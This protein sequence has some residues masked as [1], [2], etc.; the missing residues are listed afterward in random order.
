M[1]HDESINL[2]W[3]QE[4]VDKARQI[5]RNCPTGYHVVYDEKAVLVFYWEVRSLKEIPTDF[6]GEHIEIAHRDFLPQDPDYIAFEPHNSKLGSGF[7]VY[8]VKGK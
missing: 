7:F 8:S 2:K 6:T 4:K 1:T 3:G 5:V